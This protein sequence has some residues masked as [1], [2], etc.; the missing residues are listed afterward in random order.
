MGWFEK[1]NLLC[2]PSLSPEKSA[3]WMSDCEDQ[4]WQSVKL[5]SISGCFPLPVLITK[6]GRFNFVE[7][8]SLCLIVCLLFKSNFVG[9]SPS[10]FVEGIC[11][12]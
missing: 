9:K 10:L 12:L 5:K 7:S 6:E 2:F 3:C 4:T 11:V 1:K 8:F